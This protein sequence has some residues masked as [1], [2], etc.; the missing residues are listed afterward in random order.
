MQIESQVNE[1]LADKLVL[2]PDMIRP[3]EKLTDLGADSLDLV[4][5]VM[6]LET[7]FNISIPDMEMDN[8]ITVQDIYNYL[9]ANVKK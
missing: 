9:N 4:E 6:E 7:L 8:I 2:E 1:V 5:I 3:E